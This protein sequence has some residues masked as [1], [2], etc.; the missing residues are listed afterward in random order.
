MR[1]PALFGLLPLLATACHSTSAAMPAEPA[2]PA[3]AEPV[4]P[5]Q[6]GATTELA[7]GELL[8]IELPGNPSTGYVWAV[9]GDLPPQLAVEDGLPGTPAQ[10][11]PSD[12]PVVGAPQM[13]WLYFRAVQRGSAEL[14]L[15]WHRPWEADAA[16]ARTASYTITVR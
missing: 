12:R 3:H 7:R 13:Q 16:P 8:L 11:S 15:R 10:A 5:A 4:I 2:P 6:A 14:R 9:D 1:L